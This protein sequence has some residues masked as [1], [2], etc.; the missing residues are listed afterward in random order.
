MIQMPHNRWRPANTRGLLIW[1]GIFVALVF[2]FVVVCGYVLG[3]KWTDLAKKSLWDR[4]DLSIVPAVLALGGP[5]HPVGDPEDA[6]GG[7]REIL[8]PLAGSPPGLLDLARAASGGPRL[9]TYFT[10]ATDSRAH[11]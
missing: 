5:H 6:G 7:R 3:W 8:V 1:A 2:A 4:Q 11:L 10:N 9:V